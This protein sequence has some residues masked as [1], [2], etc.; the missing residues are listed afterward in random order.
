MKNV[1]QWCKLRYKCGEFLI[2]CL[3][4]C[5]YS[6]QRSGFHFG[7]IKKL[8]EIN[9]KIV[10]FFVQFSVPAL[11]F[12]PMKLQNIKKIALFFFSLIFLTLRSLSRRLQSEN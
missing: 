6:L 11:S 10:K 2:R 4:I 1:A 9:C 3:G 5:R 7:C 12:L 8:I